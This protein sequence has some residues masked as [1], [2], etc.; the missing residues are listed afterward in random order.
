MLALHRFLFGLVLLF[1]ALIPLAQA[2]SQPSGLTALSWNTGN[3][4]LPLLSLPD[5]V[6]GDLNDLL[7]YP[8]REF[9]FPISQPLSYNTDCDCYSLTVVTNASRTLRVLQL[10]RA[11]AGFYR[12]QNGPYVELEDFGPLTAIT[13]LDGT[14]YLFAEVR[15]GER[16]CVSIHTLSGNY[17]LIDYTA[18]GLIN[19]LRDSSS[20][21][22]VPAYKDSRIVSLTQTWMDQ[23]TPRA[24]TTV[25]VP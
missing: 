9:A 13:A 7:A 23:R 22:I 2:R 16:Y 14:R 4:N 18:E 17:L 8:A 6:H 25:V 12:S 21:T 11:P 20:R 15:Q 10:W 3:S 5:V 19:R 24:Q 1:V